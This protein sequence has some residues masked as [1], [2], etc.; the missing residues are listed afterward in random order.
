M[1]KSHILDLLH[2]KSVAKSKLDTLNANFKFDE[3]T[4]RDRFYLIKNIFI[5]DVELASYTE[6]QISTA[7]ETKKKAEFVIKKHREEQDD[8][9]IFIDNSAF[10][11]FLLLILFIENSNK[12]KAFYAIAINTILG[13]RYE[14][15][16][17]NR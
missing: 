8:E 5:I 11:L 2:R 12:N 9:Y 6:E 17:T 4:V 3:N 1:N 14:K 13:D 16:H 10:R 7:L 15:R